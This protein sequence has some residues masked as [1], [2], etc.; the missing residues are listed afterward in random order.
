[1]DMELKTVTMSDLF[2]QL[3]LPSSPR[4][5]AAFIARHRPLR[6]ELA[7]AD[8]PFWTNSQAAFLKEGLRHDSNWALAIDAL[9]AQ[10]RVHPQPDDLAQAAPDSQPADNN[11][12]PAIASVACVGVAPSARWWP[13][14]PGSAW[15]APPAPSSA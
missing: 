9:N 1:M 8:A 12:E 4:G 10:L 5:M 2:D 13:A 3:G 14:L 6:G 15:P 7:L 11:D